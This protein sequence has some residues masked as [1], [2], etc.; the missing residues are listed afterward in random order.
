MA[1]VNVE[2]YHAP[3]TV[4][5]ARHLEG[6]GSRAADLLG[7]RTVWCATTLPAGRDAALALC[8]CLLWALGREVAASTLDTD[9]L[10]DE[11]LGPDD[12]VVLH[13][14]LTAALAELIRERGPHVV[15]RIE[16]RP[17]GDR[18]LPA[19]MD[20]YLTSWPARQRGLRI[21]RIACLV[22]SSGT[23]ATVDVAPGPAAERRHDL[24]WSS[25]V[26]AAVAADRADTVG[27]TRRTRPG[28]PVR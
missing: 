28:V 6:A 21:E 15:G 25:A 17:T 14:P 9:A 19:A 5:A 2:R 26:A 24:G 23:V 22:P 4:R 20:A 1:I 16:A 27:G 12:V 18:V 8:D 10:G 11:Q 7:G 13:D 3:S